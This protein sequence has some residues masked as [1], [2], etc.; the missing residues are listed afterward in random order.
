MRRTGTFRLRRMAMCSRVAGRR[1]LAG[2]AIYLIFAAVV[3]IA[4]AQP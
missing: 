3:V 4:L 2:W 1:C